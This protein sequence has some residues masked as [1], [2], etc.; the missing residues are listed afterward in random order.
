[1]GLNLFIMAFGVECYF[2]GPN[3]DVPNSRLPVLCYRQV[4]P[5]P[6]DEE[7]T[8]KF[9]TSNRWEKRV[10]IPNNPASYAT[11]RT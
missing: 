1:M 7:S 11:A 5:K 4:L 6:Y 3:S 2:L 10:R 9:L 8:T